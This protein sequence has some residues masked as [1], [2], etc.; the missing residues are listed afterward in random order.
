M[1]PDVFLQFADPLPEPTLLVSGEGQILAANRAVSQRLGISA[2]QLVDRS[3][4]DVVNDS[5]TDVAHYLRVCSR[6]RSLMIGAMELQGAD[7]K[8][9]ACRSE[10]A[11]IRPGTE[12]RVAIL[13]LRLIPKEL[14]TLRFVALNRRIDEL[15]RE[16][17]RRK[18]AE[19]EARRQ[20]EALHVTLLSIGDGVISTDADG[21]VAM[22]NPVAEDLTGWRQ[23]E[24][25]GCALETVFATVN[26]LTHEPL[27]NPALRALQESETVRLAQ[28]TLLIAK[29]GSTR[30]VSNSAAPI[31]DA[32]DNF[33][34]SVL[35]FR[36]ISEAKQAESEL[37]ES[38]RRFQAVFNQQFQFM[39][40][41]TADGT[42]LESNETSLTLTGVSREQV[43]GRC[44][45]ETPW[46]DQMS[47]M[48]DQWKR[49]VAEAAAGRGPV[50]GE[51]EFLSAD[52]TVRHATAVA[53]G[54]K[55]ESGQITNILLEGHDDTNRRRS[56]SILVAQK[57]VL[58]LLVSGEPLSDV[59][60][61]ICEVI[62][63]D[64]PHT[65]I[66]T[67]LLLDD[68][69]K[70]LHTV[71]GHRAPAEYSKA[72]DGVKIGPDIGSC[73]T[74]AFLGKQVIVSDIATDPLWANF[75][76]LAM[77]HGLRAC[78]S[79]P[80]VSSQGIV[81]GTFAVYYPM[82]RE[83]TMDELR[84]VDILTRTAG[85]AIER[86]RG[87][88]A[89]RF[90][91]HLLDTVGQ[92]AIVTR[93]NGEIIYWNRFAETLY[94]WS[95]DEALGQNL[96]EICV[97][98]EATAQSEEIGKQLRD[99]Q[100]WSGEL[101]VRH[102]DGT[103][104]HAF[105]TDTP[106][107]D[108]RGEVSAVIGISVDITE[109]KHLERSLRF[110][111]DASATLAG[112]VDYETTLKKVATLAVPHFADWC[113]VDMAEPDGTLR[114]L[115]I[116]HPDPA[117]VRLAHEMDA[118]YPPRR[119]TDFGVYNVLRTGRSE[120]MAELPDSVL[121]QS[122]TDEDHLQMLRDLGLKSYMCVPLQARGK[123]LGVV[124]F[125]TAESG[126]P[127]SE[128]D[129]VFAEELARRSAIAIENSQLYQE[130]RDADRRK[131]EF[132][133]T[134]AHELRNPLAPIRNG[135]QILRLSDPQ[136]DVDRIRLM[137]ERQLNQMVRLVDDLLDVSRVTRNKLELRMERIELKT[138]IQSAI[139]T[140]QSLIEQAGHRFSCQLPSAPV[141]LD[142]DLTRLAQVF[143]NLLNNSAKYTPKGG[144]ISLVAEA[145]ADDI[146]VTVR[147]NGIGIPA[148]SL[149]SIFEAFSQVDRNL[150]RAQGGLGIGLTLVRRLI[151]MHGGSVEAF[152]DGP[153]CGSEF[154]VRLPILKDSV[155]EQQTPVSGS[156]TLPSAKRRILVVDDNRDAADSL[157]MMLSL[158]KHDIRSAHDGLTAMTEAE[159]FRPEMILL[160]IGMPDLSG[161]E[162]CRRIRQQPWSEG[163]TIVA[164]TGW[165][166]NEDRRRS[167]EAGF[168]HHLVKPVDFH[169]LNTLLEAP[170]PHT[171]AAE[172]S[173]PACSSLRVL[174]V[175]DRA[176]A[177]FLLGALLKKTGHD[178][179]TSTDGPTALK[180]ALE[181]RPDVAIL[182]INMPG[183]SG[184]EVAEQLR[185]E[186]S[187]ASVVL[188][189]MTGFGEEA[190]RQR[191]LDAGFQHH[192]VKPADIGILQDILA[193][194]TPAS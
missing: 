44:L 117:R 159:E 23:R 94:G 108:D 11:L 43:L 146:T 164:L 155:A 82:P 67:I 70:R 192:L 109:R 96:S 120:M 42:V 121:V 98:P 110:L 130:L 38:R 89:V 3:L 129:L 137:M 180:L 143:S 138:A 134:L 81:L 80:I 90:Q 93:P 34:G 13:M 132:L 150:E 51:M 148:E 190:D 32:E 140:S 177:T 74:A 26:E 91:A 56:E 119:D 16:V 154:T 158:M 104:F 22:M 118:R 15:D 37:R 136:D 193:T 76:D 160:D 170:R 31:R 19:E 194:V 144:K 55:D 172:P 59:L 100:S 157:S 30:P 12:G 153:G 181:Y 72:I 167:A 61:A 145:V 84:L 183:M 68:D 174:V 39:A 65:I 50:T 6:N 24:A 123:L 176:D 184:Y 85:V 127:Y 88:E 126:R 64:N 175:D 111:A 173:E 9:I 60:D 151:E 36:D 27:A 166:Q 92:S 124:T 191:S 77:D 163:M 10:G 169:S 113:A 4:F 106:L 97:A 75:K 95:K 78:W 105:L 147:D 185:R 5:Q 18:Q 62:E 41:L 102:R 178:V 54:L 161:Y 14:S 171:S 122:A 114:R 152:S 7:D 40:I 71:A 142:A 131:D 107:L 156:G 83:P 29:D 58:E 139:E 162:V 99:G 115:A 8:P 21:R 112:L 189:A 79:T 182:D 101:L 66:A 103:K 188:V 47:A 168:N 128:A 53:T 179:R 45:W 116:A 48:R 63:G 135:L 28:P 49:N 17:R 165:G 187:L 25:V 2:G 33:I 186:P 35:V 46:W 69:G 20:R 149:H 1:T 141:Y 125:V 73:G 86:R 52:G 57:K 87:E 133:A